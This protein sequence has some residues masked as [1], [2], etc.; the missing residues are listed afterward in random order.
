MNITNWPSLMRPA[1]RSSSKHSGTLPAD[2]AGVVQIVNTI[3][4]GL[5]T[6]VYNITFQ[7]RDSGKK[8][9]IYFKIIG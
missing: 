1:R 3:P 2:A 4:A 7:G 6:G 5:P 8:G 9:V